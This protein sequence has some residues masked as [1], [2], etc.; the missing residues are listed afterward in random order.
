MSRSGAGNFAAE[1]DH[2][3][4]KDP[5]KCACDKKSKNAEDCGSQ[6]ATGRKPPDSLNP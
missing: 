5:L 2:Q 6:T 3:P 1:L 4:D